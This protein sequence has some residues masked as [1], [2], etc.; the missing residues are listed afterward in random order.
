VNEKGLPCNQEELAYTL[1]TFGYVFLRSLRRLG[2]GLPSADEEAYLHAWNVVGHVL[3]LQA[4][5]RVDRMA[6]AEILFTQL[7]ARGIARQVKPDPRPH[8]TLALMQ[9]MQQVLPHVL[10]P[11]PVLLTRF[12]CGDVT[13][14]QLGLNTQVS[15]VSRLLFILGM[16]LILGLDRLIRVVLPGF[17][18]SG[19]LTRWV[20]E[21]FMADL[22]LSQTRQLQLP[23]TLRDQIQT[24]LNKRRSMK[25]RPGNR[26]QTSGSK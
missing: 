23:W 1:L 2:L 16:G 3:G 17:T 26:P 9:A 12:L 25:N 4:D 8:L 20:G 13:S 15:W 10:K 24:E 22:L 7:Q 6:E 18:F 14:A 21:R 5:L 19:L 11:M